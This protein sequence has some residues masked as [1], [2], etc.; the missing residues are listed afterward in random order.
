M[1]NLT[2]ITS[3]D[4]FNILGD[5]NNA[6]GAGGGAGGGLGGG[7]GGGFGGG[8]GGGGGGNF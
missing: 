7:G 8:L 5:A 6:L 4:T 3:V 2:T 1:P